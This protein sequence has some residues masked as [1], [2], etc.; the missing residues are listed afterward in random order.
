MRKD[1]DAQKPSEARSKLPRGIRPD[2]LLYVEDDDDNWEVAE[3]RLGKHYAMLRAKDDESACRI[4]RERRGEID[5]ILMDIELRG[6]ALNGV[7]LTELLRGN[8]GPARDS[9]P[10]Y[11]RDLP[12]LSKPIIYVTAHGARY[13]NVRLLLSGADRVI[14][15]PVDFTALQVALSELLLDRTVG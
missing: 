15:K 2:V 6:C 14:P 12:V 8:R 4:V 11:A 1:P 7:E 3:L 9:L 13:T 10:A 5:I